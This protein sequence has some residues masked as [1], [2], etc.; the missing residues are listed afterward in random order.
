MLTRVPRPVFYS[1]VGI[2]L[3]VAPVARAQETA[4]ADWWSL[5]PL[6]RPL[7]PTVK[8]PAWARNPIDVF[9]LAKIESIGLKPSPEADRA[10]LI[11]RVT[12]DL[13]GLPP[14]PEEIDGFV[15]DSRHDAYERLV[16]RLLASPSYG[17]RWARHWLDVVH[18]GETHGYDK[19]KPRPN[20]WHYRDYV[21]RAFNE[22]K[23]YHRFVQEQLAADVLF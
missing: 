20:A 2:C 6:A 9:I 18:F 8:Q 17:E 11:R 19:D 10:T 12:F 22:D 13:I 7:I 21:I 16:D 3:A 23:P 14:T 1:I 5:K 15:S 4:K